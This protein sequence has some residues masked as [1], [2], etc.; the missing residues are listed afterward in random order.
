MA[1]TSFST[2]TTFQLCIMTPD[3]RLM[4]AGLNR[5]CQLDG[6]LTLTPTCSAHR[7]T[8]S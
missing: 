2:K 3:L 1:S 7:T 4:E 5:V 8:C 6:V